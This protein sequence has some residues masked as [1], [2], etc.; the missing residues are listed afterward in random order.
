[1]NNQSAQDEQVQLQ[2]HVLV[3]DD[4]EQFSR[5]MQWLLTERGL[6]VDQAYTFE[7]ALSQIEIKKPQLILLDW[8]LHHQDGME[9]IQRFHALCP[10]TPIVLLTAF[11]SEE[12]ASSCSNPFTA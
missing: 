6:T 5:F 1:M 4:D 8:Q 11:S 9:L 3:V 2:G 7:E 10:L 12:V